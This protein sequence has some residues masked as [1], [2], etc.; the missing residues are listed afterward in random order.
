MANHSTFFNTQDNNLAPHQLR[1]KNRKRHP[2]HRLPFV[3]MNKSGL[4]FWAVPKAGGYFGGNKT[5]SALAHIY[6]K[7]L[8]EHDA[9]AIGGVLQ[10]IVLNMFGCKPG[11]NDEQDALRGQVVGFFFEIERWLSDAAKHRD[12]GLE[13]LDNK[14]LLKVANDGLNFDGLALDDGQAP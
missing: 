8:K 5:G 3:E 1:F 10:S 14:T 9:N 11:V 13:Q 2:L 6:M 4:T 12:Y 7:H